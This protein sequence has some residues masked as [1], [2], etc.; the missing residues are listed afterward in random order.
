MKCNRY[1][2]KL[3]R[4]AGLLMSSRQHMEGKDLSAK[5]IVRK[6][7]KL[8]ILT[9]QEADAKNGEA[10]MG[11]HQSSLSIRIV[12]RLSLGPPIAGKLL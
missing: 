6:S 5:A 8:G 4:F 9:G 3:T 2:C 12:G 11:K 1:S 7:G 10:I